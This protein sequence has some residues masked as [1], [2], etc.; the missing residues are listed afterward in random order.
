MA[1]WRTKAHASV[2]VHLFPS[3]RYPRAEH[4]LCDCEMN[5]FNIGL[6]MDACEPISFPTLCDDAHD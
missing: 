5:T 4:N 3:C 2:P 1:C 6:R